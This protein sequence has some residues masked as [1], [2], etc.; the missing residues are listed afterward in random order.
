LYLLEDVIVRVLGDGDTTGGKA[1][2]ETEVKAGVETE[3][4]AGG[5]TEVEGMK[6]DVRKRSLSHRDLQ[7]P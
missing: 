3:V 1:G 5:E 6:N 7:I 2:G 4:K